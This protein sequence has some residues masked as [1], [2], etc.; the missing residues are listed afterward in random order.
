[1]PVLYAD[2]AIAIILLFFLYR[3][4][5]NG[6]IQEASAIVGM[7]GGFFLAK[8]Y[9]PDLA[10][11]FTTYLSAPTAYLAAFLAIV[12]L[13]LILA[14]IVARILGSLLKTTLATWVDHTLGSLLGI[15][16]GIL[17]TSILIYIVTYISPQA[18]LLMQTSIFAPYYDIVLGFLSNF[19]ET[20]YMVEVIV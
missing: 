17:L 8:M 15:T 13:F 11:Y 4:F 1:M 9:A 6:F 19:L 16:K 3:G 10:V 2:I 20:N 18:T 14:S 12:T 7:L 5:S